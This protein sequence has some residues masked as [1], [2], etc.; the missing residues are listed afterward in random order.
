[1]LVVGIDPGIAITGYGFIRLL[2]AGRLEA[3]DYGVIRTDAGMDLPR[4]LAFLH[5]RLAELL[6]Q[7][8]PE[9]AAVERLFFQRNVSTAMA[10]GEARG[11]V[12]LALAQ[13]GLSVGEY[14][15]Q[16]V[17]QAVTAYGSAEKR[18]MQEMIRILLGLPSVPR[19]DDAAD[20]L[21]VAV[22]HLQHARLE[23]GAGGAT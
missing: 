2:A 9:A 11:V 18:Q 8:Q 21:A 23:R 3:V 19:P 20:A 10:V 14:T 7:H 17:K 22:C 1:M 12:V 5:R 13:A 6:A 4:R 15:P 16:E